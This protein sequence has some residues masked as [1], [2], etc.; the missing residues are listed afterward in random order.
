MAAKNTTGTTGAEAAA[1]PAVTT[2]RLRNTIKDM[3][4]MSQ[5]GFSSIEALARV[6]LMALENP[7]AHRFHEVIA[8]TLETIAGIAQ[9]S[10]DAV[11]S[12]AE[13]VG[14]NWI[15]VKDQRRMDARR[16]ARERDAQQ[17]GST[18]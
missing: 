13:A 2:D 1:L 10:L 18:R 8:K 15:E 11:N 12:N 14:C 17:T 16:V 9:T 6:T 4:A 7:D 5:D 3:D